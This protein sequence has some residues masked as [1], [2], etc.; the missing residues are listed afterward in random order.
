MAWLIATRSSVRVEEVDGM[1]ARQK[2]VVTRKSA[3]L[4]RG[5]VIIFVC[6]FSSGRKRN[7]LGKNM[8]YLSLGDQGFQ[9]S[10]E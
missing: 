3:K 7:C 10:C 4:N 5:F 6:F 2:V 9:F 1:V 8:Y